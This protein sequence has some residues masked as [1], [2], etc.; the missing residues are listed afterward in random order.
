MYT[1]HVHEICLVLDRK[2]EYH[3]WVAAIFDNLHAIAALQGFMQFSWFR[4]SF[5]KF[6]P[7]SLKAQR[8]KHR[9]I[10]RERVDARLTKATTRSDIWSLVIAA[11]A[12]SP[13]AAEHV[14]KEEMYDNAG[15][16]MIAGTET[17][18]T[19]LSGLMYLLMTNKGKMSKLQ[20]EVRNLSADQLNLLELPKLSYLHACIEE[21]LR[22]YPPVPIGLPRRTPTEGTIICDRFV[23]GNVSTFRLCALLICIAMSQRRLT[24]RPG[25]CMRCTAM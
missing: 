12:S 3:E 17:T 21:G 2:N 6:L 18:A 5:D 13:D 16:F 23:P 4:F 20:D 8:D 11:N 9:Q 15:L 19:L 1:D 7:Q 14:R 10:T 24:Y 25:P 22:V